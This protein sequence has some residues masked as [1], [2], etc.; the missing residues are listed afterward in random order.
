MLQLLLDTCMVWRGSRWWGVGVVLGGCD[1]EGVVVDGGVLPVQGPP[2]PP[3]R[4]W[5]RKMR[6]RGRVRVRVI[7]T[8]RVRVGRRTWQLAGAG[9]WHP[10]IAAVQAP[11]SRGMLVGPDLTGRA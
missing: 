2:S 5:A 10:P 9:M 7:V 8:V 3:L 6:M 4:S 11:S 1:G